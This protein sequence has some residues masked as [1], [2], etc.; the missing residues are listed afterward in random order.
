MTL[1]TD[2]QERKDAPMARGLLDYFPDALAAVAHVSFVGNEQHNP[3]QP[4]HWERA[5]STDHADCIVRHLAERGTIDTD[6]L[7]HAAKVAW[8]ALALLQT[9]LEEAENEARGLYTDMDR[10]ME[11]AVFEAGADPREG[12]LEMAATEPGHPCHFELPDYRQGRPGRR[13]DFDVVTDDPHAIPVY[14]RGFQP[15]EDCHS[16]L[17]EHTGTCSLAMMKRYRGS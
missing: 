15:C 14:A 6:G 5:L 8:R 1:P 13:G 9:E 12:S 10:P 2:R 3:G 4:L 16:L 7:R 17:C 11:N